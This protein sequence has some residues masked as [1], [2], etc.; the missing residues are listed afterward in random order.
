M[1]EIELA[2]ARPVVVSK[3][4]H[5]LDVVT[6]SHGFDATG[7]TMTRAARMLAFNNLHDDS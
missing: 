2:L 5:L 1:S 6:L 4:F 3:K 7:V